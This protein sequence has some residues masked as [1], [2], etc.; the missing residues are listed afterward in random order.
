M[1]DRFKPRNHREREYRPGHRGRGGIHKFSRRGDNYEQ[2]R[3]H[4]NF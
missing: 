2:R 1:K 3:Q 4:K